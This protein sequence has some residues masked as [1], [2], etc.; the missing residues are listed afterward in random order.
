MTVHQR[1][2]LT[3]LFVM[4]LKF[5]RI[6]AGEY[7]V[8]E[9]SK[10]VGYIQKKSSKWIFYKCNN[11]SVLGNPLAVE[12]TLKELKI[13]AQDILTLGVSIDSSAASGVSEKESKIQADDKKFELMREMLNNNYVIDLNEYEQTEDGLDEV[14]PFS[15]FLTEEEIAAL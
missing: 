2:L 7:Q 9:G 13:K 15:R 1:Q 11:P 14:T 3:S 12:K 5:S 6:Q 10:M 4:I 8:N